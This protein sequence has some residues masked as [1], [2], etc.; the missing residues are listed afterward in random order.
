MEAAG[1]ESLGKHVHPVAVAHPDL[2]TIGH[3]SK[4]GSDVLLFR[5]LGQVS[6]PVFP[7]FPGSHPA[8]QLMYQGLHAVADSQHRQLAVENP[9]RNRGSAGVIDA[10]GPAGENHT[11]WH[12][13]LGYPFPTGGGRDDF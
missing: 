9:V 10:G 13:A 1:G 12:E 7:L 8:A 5:G 3:T 6:R 11:P 4:Y 2:E